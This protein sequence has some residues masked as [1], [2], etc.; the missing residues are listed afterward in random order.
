MI[1]GLFRWNAKL[2]R[3]NFRA[4]IYGMPEKVSLS[5]TLSLTLSLSL[6]FSLS[7]SATLPLHLKDLSW[8]WQQWWINTQIPCWSRWASS[9]STV[10]MYIID[11]QLEETTILLNLFLQIPCKRK[12]FQEFNCVQPDNAATKGSRREEDKGRLHFHCILMRATV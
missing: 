8:N 11:Y 7:H 5:L 3:H 9:V 4:H 2:K 1:D 10:F 6:S 12:G